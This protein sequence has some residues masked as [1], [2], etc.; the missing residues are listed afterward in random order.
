MLKVYK[1]FKTVLREKKLAYKGIVY[2]DV[3]DNLSVSINHNEDV[4]YLFVGF[5]VLSNAEK[6]FSIGLVHSAGQNIIKK[7]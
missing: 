2:R 3:V 6:K 1:D 7:R 5:S 4:N